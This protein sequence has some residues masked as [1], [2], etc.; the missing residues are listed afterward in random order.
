MYFWGG[1]VKKVFSVI[2]ILFLLSGCTSGAEKNEEPS[3]IQPESVRGVWLFYREISMADEKGGTAASFS[4]KISA[5]FDNCVSMGIN[6][7]FFHV[8]PFSDSFYPSE[9]FPMSEYLTGHQGGKIDY[10][11]LKIAVTLAH[12]RDLSIHAWINPFRISFSSDISKL[13]NNNPAIK[14]I[15]EKNSRVCKVNGGFYFN[16]ACKDNHRLIINGVREIVNNYDVDGVH[17]DDYFYPD[18]DKSIDKAEYRKYISDG[19]KLSLS[20][21]RIQWVNS[22]VSSLYSAVKAVNNNLVVSVSPAGN[23][24]N[25]YEK[26]YADVK[27]WGSVEGYC[28]WLIPQIY[29]GYESSVLDYETALNQWKDIASCKDVKLLAGLGAYK[30]LSGET[31]EWKSDDIIERQWL[32]AENESYDGFVLFSYS[33]IVSADFGNNGDFLKSLS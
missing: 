22:F 3:K 4:E 15:K 25:N 9:L 23:I 31:D 24:S 26:L 33:S 29:Y 30:V 13:S 10:D 27:R 21:W 1:K 6:T 32:D 12:E 8:R 11:P 14:L 16:P 28:D 20:A 7:V 17:I 5:I 19:G 2:L 18:T